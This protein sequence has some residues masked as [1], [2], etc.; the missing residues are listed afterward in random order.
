MTAIRIGEVYGAIVSAER[1]NLPT[2]REVQAD[3]QRML[4]AQTAGLGL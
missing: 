1:R 2:V 3:Y 4:R